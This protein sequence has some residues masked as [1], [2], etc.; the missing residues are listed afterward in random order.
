MA[1][2]A[3]KMMART[4]VPFSDIS[5]QNAAIAHELNAAVQRVVSDSSFVLGPAVTAFEESFAD[6]C[7]TKFAVGC[8]SGT[9]AIHL[10]LR[11]LGVGPGDEVITVSHTFVGTVWGIL[12]SG[13]TP[14]FVDIEADTMLMDVERV[15][16][17]ISERTRA[18]IPVHLYGHPV[19]M[20]PL[21]DIARRHGLYVV[22]DAAQAHGARYKGRR[23]G[24]LGDIGCFSFYPGKNLG[25][26]GE[27]GAA[28][29]GDSELAGRMRQLRDHAQPQRYQ[30]QE[31]GYNY[32]MDGIQGAVLGVKL[33][34]LDS[35]NEQR[36]EWAGH[37]SRALSQLS[38]L[39]VPVTRSWAEPVYHLYVVRHPRRDELQRGLSAQGI[40]TGLHY[41]VPVHLQPA[42]Q[43]SVQPIPVLRNTEQAAQTA[44]SLPM[45][46]ELDRASV[47]RVITAVTGQTG[48]IDP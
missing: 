22:E 43:E 36:R 14:V 44:L 12:Y 35:W 6:Y 17:A 48:E 39:G 9:S 29:T 28:L 19:D 13:A 10:A 45:F 7:E 18:I 11:A 34:Y 23:V 16:S 2:T 1:V 46:A 42:L 20:D 25:A 32:R 15:E 5:A 24:S 4:G 40:A 8:N 33:R 31:L 3:E 27:A 30:H 21:M 38:D 37:Y 26:W 47:D 41:P